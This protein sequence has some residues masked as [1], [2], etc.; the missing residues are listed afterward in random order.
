MTNTINLTHY[1]VGGAVRDKLLGLDIRDKDWVV[2][3]HTS[4]DMLERGFTAI[5]KSFPVFLHPDSK[6]EYAL[7]RKERKVSS[8]YTGFECIS[9]PSISIEEDLFR[10]DLSINAIAEDMKGNLIDPYNGQE[11]IKS[12]ILRHVSPAFSED[13]LRV[14]R[15]ARFYA[16]FYH[17]GF[18]ISKETLDLMQNMAEQGELTSL[19]PERIWVETEKALLSPNP[20][21]YFQ[22]LRDCKALQFLMPEIEALFGIPQRAKY[23]PEIDTGIHTLMVLEQAAYIAEKNKLSNADRVSLCYAAICH[24]LGKAKSPE[25]MLPRHHGHEKAG[26]PLVKALSKRLRVPKTTEQLALISCEFHLHCH[27]ALELKPSTIEKL[28]RQCD[29]YRNPERFYLFLLS[30]K[31]DSRGRTGFESRT[32]PQINYLQHCLEIAKDINARDLPSEILQTGG[33]AVGQA[34]EKAR[35]SAISRINKVEFEEEWP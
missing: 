17:L 7:A 26:L 5:G 32:Y 33:K 18:S 15:V 19:S 20:E 25:S 14:L 6:E 23:H 27:R 1:L 24:D 11:D 35:I 9:D 8:G 12:R 13:P 28:L 31:A 3:G 30:S 2:V 29:A 22:A 16:R 21:K 4:E 34:L 10:R